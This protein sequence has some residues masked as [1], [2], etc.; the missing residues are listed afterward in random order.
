[1]HPRRGNVVRD[2]VVHPKRCRQRSGVRDH[3]Q[4]ICAGPCRRQG[5]R[6]AHGLGII[7]RAEVDLPEA[8]PNVAKLPVVPA[9]RCAATPSRRTQGVGCAT[10]LDSRLTAVCAMSLPVIDAPVR[11]L[12][13]V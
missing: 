7:R 11:R 1:M 12:I 5:C 6:A 10:V 9:S 2:G 8:S 13:M 4:S 3:R